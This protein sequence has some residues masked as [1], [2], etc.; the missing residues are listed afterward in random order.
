MVNKSSLFLILYLLSTVLSSILPIQAGPAGINQPVSNITN[1]IQ[2]TN[3]TNSLISCSC[4]VFLSGQFVRGSPKPPVGYPPITA[5][6][7][8]QFPCN[9]IGVNKCTKKC[10]DNLAGHLARSAEIIC[11]SIDRDAFKERAHLFIKNCNSGW[12]NTNLS[13]GKEYCCKNGESYK[14]PM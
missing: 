7:E 9:P 1:V 2:N 14:C 5:D 4:A 6:I 13:A 12:I 3:E 11:M 8:D 10:L